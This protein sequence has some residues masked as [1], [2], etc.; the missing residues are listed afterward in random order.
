[1]S[2]KSLSLLQFSLDM[3]SKKLKFSKEVFDTLGVDE[4]A[5]FEKIIKAFAKYCNTYGAEDADE[6]FHI[7]K[8][9]RLYR[10][11]CRLYHPDKNLEEE[12]EKCEDKVQQL[13]Y[14]LEELNL[15]DVDEKNKFE[16]AN[17]FV[18]RE[19]NAK[20][21]KAYS[22]GKRGGPLIITDNTA[23]SQAKCSTSMVL[24]PASSALAWHENRT[25]RIRKYA[26]YYTGHFFDRQ[27]RKKDKIQ[28]YGREHMDWK[29]EKLMKL[30]KKMKKDKDTDIRNR[31]DQ[32]N[33]D[34]Y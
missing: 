4:A 32:R 12:H 8:V 7:A 30:D 20:D 9:K 3:A 13:Q 28:R 21:S 16:K 25:S 24:V 15:Q 10:R 11:L 1:M 34:Y 31:R 6:E 5:D 27:E 33:Y 14:V 18:K 26:N 23:S 29:E 19:H 22:A 17:K 2:L